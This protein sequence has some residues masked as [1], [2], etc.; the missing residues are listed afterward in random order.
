[1]FVAHAASCSSGSRARLAGSRDPPAFALERVLADVAVAALD[2]RSALLASAASSATAAAARVRVA[3][4]NSRTAVAD[5]LADPA[6]VAGDDRQ[7]GGK[8]LEQDLRQAPRS[9]SSAAGRGPRGSARRRPPSWARSPRARP[10]RRARARRAPPRA[11]R[12]AVPRRRPP[13]ASRRP[14]ATSAASAS[15]SMSGFFSVSSR[16][17][18]SIVRGRVVVPAR[19]RRRPSTI[20][21]AETSETAISSSRLRVGVV[22]GQLRADDDHRAA[23]G[24]DPEGSV[25]QAAARC[26]ARRARM[27][28][29]ACRRRSPGARRAPAACGA[30]ARTRQGRAISGC[31]PSSQ[32]RSTSPTARHAAASDRA[33]RAARQRWPA[34]RRRAAATN[35]TP[36]PTG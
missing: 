16:P 14:R 32:T 13:A 34:S 22:A 7:A 36:S 19:R 3:G 6:D 31:G 9:T 11:R 12:A 24:E 2:Q 1:M 25:E 29:G 33:A 5:R 17:T 10:G 18:L 20:W 28:G 30:A 15:A 23:A 26:S 35:S 8:G 27:P 21:S 4:A